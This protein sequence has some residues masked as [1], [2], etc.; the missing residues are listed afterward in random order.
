MLFTSTKST[1]CPPI[2]VNWCLQ[3]VLIGPSNYGVWEK[4]NVFTLSIIMKTRWRQS[5]GILITQSCSPLAIA[6]VKFRWWIY[7]KASKSQFTNSNLMMF[8]FKWNGISQDSTW[9]SVILMGMFLLR[10]STW[11]FFPTEK[12][13]LSFTSLTSKTTLKYIYP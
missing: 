4:T 6:P 13:T 8:L 10:S 7:S 1:N 9:Q 12:M 11:I 2:L 3:E 5:T